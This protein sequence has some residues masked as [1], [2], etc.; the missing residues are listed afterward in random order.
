VDIFEKCAG[1]TT[2]R[3]AIAAGLYPYFIPL[4]ESEGTEATFRGHRLIMCGSNNYLGLTTDPRVRQAA[5]DAVL[6]F[7]TSCTGSRFLNGTLEMHEQLESELAE[8]VGKQ[9]ALVFSTGMQANLGAISALVGRNDTVILDKDDHASIVDGARLGWGE[10]KRFRHNDMASLERILTRIP[11]DQG[12]L[13]VVDGL[14]SMGGDIAPLPEMTVLSKK[15]HARLRVDDAHALGVL[16]GGRGTAAHFGLTDDVDLIMSTFSKS[17]ASL[18]GFVAGE[19]DVIHYI[20]HHARTLIFSASIPPANAAAALA[21]LKIMREEPERVQ[22]L[23]AVAER[24]RKQLSGL[25]FN[26]GR[27]TTPIIPIIIGDDTKTLLTWKLLF[28]NGVF[29]NPVLSPAVPPGQQLLRTSYMATHTDE[30]LDHVIE[31]YAMVGKQMCLI[32]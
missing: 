12:K 20:K 29:V 27:S 26:I 31:V 21:A 15:Y 4:T 32:D 19:E 18:G 5:I 14:Y 13:I 3:E 7:G 24:M 1:F 17:F 8:W 9:A 30:Q 22:R 11:E 23:T 10:T 25:G 2:A 28:E 16:G 6:R